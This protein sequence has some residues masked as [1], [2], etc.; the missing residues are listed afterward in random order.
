MQ[1]IF[2]R[3]SRSKW[4]VLQPL[5][6]EP[7]KKNVPVSDLFIWRKGAGWETFFELTDMVGMYDEESCHPLLRSVE[8]VIFE[9]RGNEINRNIIPTL[10]HKR[11]VVNISEMVPDNS[12]AYGTFCVLHQSSPKKLID[13]D[14]NLSERG[15]VSYTYMQ[16]ILR[17]YVHGNL[18]AIC[19]SSDGNF[20]KL[21]G[22][23][24]LRREYRLQYEFIGDYEY[25]VV[26]VNPSNNTKSIELLLISND[27]GA[28]LSTLLKSIPSGGCYV[29]QIKP[30]KKSLRVVIRSRLV[31]ARPLV[32]IF[33]N[34]TMTVF[35]G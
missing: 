3:F 21:G 35:H 22:S 24:F 11:Q 7:K 28:T 29:F 33:N 9:S 26:L 19:K 31:M 16:S 17:G 20:Q 1:N 12:G 15:Y 32:F 13:L 10:L 6:I 25:E 30:E 8:I 18:N 5:V 2:K 34:N 27:N 23:S 4:T 14:G